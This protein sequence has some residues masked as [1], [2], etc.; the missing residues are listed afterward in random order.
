MKTRSLGIALLV[1][2]AFSLAACKSKVDHG[3]GRGTVAGVDLAK[4]EVTLDHG[5]IPGLMDAMTM[6]FTVSDPKVLDG[7]APGAKVE[8]D[9]EIRDGTHVVTGIRPR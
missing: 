5:A 8:F 7:V 6:T 9:V 1:A 4:R 2:I 3:T